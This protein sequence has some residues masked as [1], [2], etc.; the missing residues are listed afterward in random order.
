MEIQAD[1]FQIKGLVDWLLACSEPWTRY[2]TLRDLLDLPDE[3]P[4]VRQ[5]R[6]ELLNNPAVQ[7]L[8]QLVSPLE[9]TPIKRHND[10]GHPLY[11][12]SVLADFGLNASDPT[13]TPLLQ[14][15]L[16]H[17]S[18]QGAYQSL[19][20]IPPSF[21]GT[22]EDIWG[23]MACDAPTIL[24]I[25]LDMGAGNQ[26]G[27]QEATKHLASLVEDNGWRCSVS[28][29]MGKFRGPGRKGDPCPIATLIA[30]KALSL[31]PGMAESPTALKGIKMLL[32][33]W[34]K[35]AETKY[36]LFGIGT[37]FHKLKYP[38]VWY[39]ILHV[40][41]VLSRFP[42]ARSDLRFEQMLAEIAPLRSGDEMGRCTAASM[43]QSWKGWSFADKKAPSPWLTFLVLRILKRVGKIHP[44]TTNLK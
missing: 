6:L 26:P 25:L 3:D 15:L 40:A 4:D 36:Y 28:V 32:D 12:L 41:E 44:E 17:Q 9:N 29:E 34:E 37:D 5:A 7:S 31:A 1:Q 27:I 23:W 2:R 20:N 42:A 21:G 30:L 18:A 35:R 14:V 43:Y 8:I 38:F 22:G 10:A 33:H 13:I 16:S 11:R 19:A 24:S 39:D